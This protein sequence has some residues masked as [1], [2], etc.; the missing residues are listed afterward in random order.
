MYGSLALFYTVLMSIV[1]T[2]FYLMKN[3]SYEKVKLFD[4]NINVFKFICLYFFSYS[5]HNA[6]LNVINEI[7]EP[8]EKKAMKIIKYSY[9]I[10]VMTYVLVLFSGYF[11]TL[12]Q[13]K[14]IFVDRDDQ[15]IFLLIGKVLYTI[16]LTCHIAL[17]VYISKPSV[18]ML[19]NKNVQFT[20]RE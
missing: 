3:F 1:E 7:R 11:S 10:E 6:I 12:D 17:Y 9:I 14:E 19:I 4:L 15:S 8:T 5:T 16:S 20:E 18:E 13:T 2:P